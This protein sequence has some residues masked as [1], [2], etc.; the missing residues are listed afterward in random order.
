MEAQSNSGR[1]SADIVKDLYNGQKNKT[2]HAF[3]E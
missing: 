3:Y 2:D 1:D